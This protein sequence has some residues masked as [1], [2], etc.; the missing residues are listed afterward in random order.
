VSLVAGLAAYVA[1][2]F[3]EDRTRDETGDVVFQRMTAVAGLAFAVVL[4]K[5]T[6]SAPMGRHV[7]EGVAAAYGGRDAERAIANIRGRGEGA[8]RSRRKFFVALRRRRNR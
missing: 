4:A 3:S 2:V 6:A 8:G 1:D 5:L 7:F